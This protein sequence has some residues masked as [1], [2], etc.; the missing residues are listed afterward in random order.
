MGGKEAMRELLKLD[1][2][3][4]AIV[5]SGYSNDPVMAN[6]RDHGFRAMIAKPYTIEE[7]A[8]VLHEVLDGPSD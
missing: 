4:C 3:V 5:S 1:P 6:Y 7:I 8:R 2:N